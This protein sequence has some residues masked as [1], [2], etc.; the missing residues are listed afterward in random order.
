MKKE[1]HFARLN[2]LYGGNKSVSRK[3]FSANPGKWM[4]WL[5]RT[6]KPLNIIDGRG[7]IRGMLSC[8]KVAPQETLSI[9][10]VLS[11][12]DRLADQA[13]QKGD[14]ALCRELDEISE[15]IE[16]HALSEEL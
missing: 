14:R 6:G 13:R 8:P 10:A 12:L 5:I 11:K 4:K 16:I 15:A 9:N 3:D 2:R 1:S 7:C